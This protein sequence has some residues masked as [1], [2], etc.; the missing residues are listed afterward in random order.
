MQY[1]YYLID[2]FTNE[3]FQGSPIVVF[4]EAEGLTD[5]QMQLI[6]REMNQTET[7]FLFS[8]FLLLMQHGI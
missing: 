8:Y 7:V 2:A 4:P 3:P 6:A 5:E 1:Q